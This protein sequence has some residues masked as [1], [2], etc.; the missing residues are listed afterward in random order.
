MVGDGVVGVAQL[1]CRRIVNY[2][3]AMI[4]ILHLRNAGGRGSQVREDGY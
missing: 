4:A 1:Q 2:D 3:I